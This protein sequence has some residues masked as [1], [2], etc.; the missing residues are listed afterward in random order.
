MRAKPFTR[1]VSALLL[2]LLAALLTLAGFGDRTLFA[3]PTP[4]VRFETSPPDVPPEVLIGEDFVFKVRFKNAPSASIGYGP[5]VDVVLGPGAN[6]AK[7][8]QSPPCACDGVTFVQASLVDVN[9]GPVPLVSHSSPPCASSALHPFPGVLPVLVPPGGQLVT[10][11]LPFGSVDA[12]QPEFVVEVT[13]HVSNLADV[14]T[15]IEIFARG[16][17]RY[18]ADALNNAPPDWPIVSDLIP[19]QTPPADQQT[20]PA[21]WT[22]Q[23]T[24][25]P[26]VMTVSKKYLGPE[27]ETA[28]GPN[29]IQRYE[30]TLDIA[31]GQTVTNLTVT[32]RLQNNMAFHQVTQIPSCFAVTAP[33]PDVPHN[34]PNNDLTFQCPLRAGVAGPDAVFLFEFFIPDLDANNNAILPPGTCTAQS[35]DGVKAGGDWMPI[36]PCDPGPVS[37]GSIVSPADHT[38]A[39]RCLAIQKDVVDLTGIPPGHPIPGDVLEYTLRFQL[40]DFK[41]AGNLKI[42]DILSDGQSV[43]LPSMTLTVTDQCG[44]TSG[45]I[46]S[47]LIQ[48]TT[49]CGSGSPPAHTQLDI[50]LSAAIA[51]LATPTGPP[52]HQAGVLTGGHAFA[53]GSTSLVPAIGTITFQTVIDDA[54]QCPVTSPHDRHVDKDDPLDNNVT[55]MADVLTNGG[56][57]LT[58][59]ASTGFIAKDDSHAETAIAMDL[60]EKRVFAVQRG[61]SEICGP[62]TSPCAAAPDVLPGDSV[63]F[64]LTK[65][66]WSGDAENLTIRDWLPLPVLL[67][68][69]GG[70][71][72]TPCINPPT[73][74]SCLG[75]NNTIPVVPV[76]TADGATNSMQW[77]YGTFNNSL[78]LPWTIELLFTR[79]VTNTPFADGL[80]LTNEAQECES[81]TFGVI[82]CQNAIAQIHVREPALKIT[83]GIVST[84]NPNAVF[85]PPQPG[86]VAFQ[87]VGGSCPRFSQ[88]ITSAGL[89]FTPIDSNVSNVDA[90]DCVT[91]AIVVE[92]TGGS[93]AYDIKLREIFPLDPVDAPYCFDAH[94]STL[95]V[96]D[97]TGLLIPF[98]TG[99]GRSLPITLQ[100]PLPAANTSGSNI[101]VIT[102]DACVFPDIEPQCCPNFAR[103]ENYASTPGGP[104]FVDSGFGGPLQDDAQLCVVPRATKLVTATSE[105]HTSSGP[106][107]QLAVGE[108]IQY[109]LEVVVP[110]TTSSSTYVLQDFLPPGLSYRPGSMTATPLPPNVSASNFPSLAT[111]G[112]PCS[113]GG[114]GTVS[115]DFGTVSNSNNNNAQE[116][117]VVEFDALVCNVASNQDGSALDNRFAVVVNG[118]QV[119]TS[120]TLPAVVVEPHLTISKSAAAPSLTTGATVAYTIA[121]ANNG[122]ATAF[123]VHLTDGLPACLGN[124]TG[125]VINTSGGVTGVTNTSSTAALSVTIV[126]I[127]VGGSVNVQYSAALTCTNCADLFNTARVT[128]TSL[129]GPFGTPVNPTGSPTPGASGQV[130]GERDHSGLVNDYAAA[131]TASLCCVQAPGGMVA[132]YPLN[133][134]TGATAI[135]DIAPPPSTFNNVGSPQLGSVG[136]VSGPLPLP[137]QVNGSLHFAGFG[138]SY[139][140]V[141]SHSELNFGGSSFSIDAWVGR[142]S[143]CNPGG[144]SGVVDKLDTSANSGFSL[145]LQQP[146]FGAAQLKLWLNGV[147]FVSTG[148]IPAG[149]TS[150][151]HIAVTFDVTQGTGTFF[152]NGSP[153]GTFAAAAGP[154]SNAIPMWIG[155]TRVPGG[156]CELA[157]DELEIFNVALSQTDL[158]S[159]ANAG[160]AGKCVSG[161]LCVTNFEDRN[162]NGVRDRG[163]PLLLGWTFDVLDRNSVS[164]GTITTRPGRI[165]ACL[166]A[167][168]PGT[169][170]VAARPQSGWISTTP[171]R[172]SVTVSPGQTADLPFGHAR[173]TQRQEVERR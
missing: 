142:I 127:P 128:W 23:A 105:A 121:I 139:V 92:N 83:K 86:P 151:S 168:A 117:I 167:L 163:E 100:N 99:P 111:G 156:Q 53:P 140:E 49:F 40:S 81:N 87:P 165:A 133:E 14:G 5:F 56:T 24:T 71:N 68:A 134:L 42:Q 107:E 141:P 25:K 164:V 4:K 31:N 149:S 39:D 89:A 47:S 159:I 59:P 162:R 9:G 147:T 52:R 138:K 2:Q 124:L 169:Y 76:Y 61:G 173:V 80:F 144:L 110:E 1:V 135:D 155:A 115:F 125:V 7:P 154:I 85:S 172:R 15:P 77:D 126:S 82:F 10:L 158:Q 166:T 48:T 16:G 57:C 20:D 113:A 60:L 63:T 98:T 109:R 79:D 157:I 51:V 27:N 12:T 54:Y 35:T 8:P 50:D 132:W 143:T 103:V 145:Y 136:G 95:C 94:F 130:D 67:V 45:S 150:W 91:F 93:A 119:A 101:A 11:E 62:T 170:T 131:A 69:G 102:F 152:I 30:L 36:D 22:A 34:T 29:F 38:L 97:G 84:T 13:A 88:P 73:G 17:F 123:D 41:T 19:L 148:S 104:S 118:Q 146:T 43:I 70:H 18:G 28:T 3:A 78:N 90:N 65:T 122:T 46:P 160:P 72:N 66:I 96:T 26:T 64:Q 74:A 58:I 112:L 153:A 55:I 32:D 114:G 21:Q 33:V 6:I 116:L 108:I 75:P 129:P 161:M 171:K 106:P 44:T 137:G 37:L 120:N